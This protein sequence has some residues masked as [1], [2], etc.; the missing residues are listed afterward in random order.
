[1]AFKKKGLPELGEL[2]MC[3]VR[4]LSP[5]SAFVELDEYDHVEGMLHISEIALRGVKNIKDHLS[6]N[7]KI[8]CKVLRAKPGEV[9]VSLKR[10]NSGARKQ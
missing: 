2:V 1:M 10:V 5:H 4:Q 7:K 3:T 8:V 6:V 9:D